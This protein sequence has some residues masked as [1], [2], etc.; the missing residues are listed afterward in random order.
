M[1]DQDD[2]ME[3][4]RKVLLIDDDQEFLTDLSFMLGG[5]YQVVT[6]TGGKEGIELLERDGADL[7]ILDLN[8]P[9]FYGEDDA[10]EGVAVLRTIRGKRGALRGARIPVVILS[11]AIT[12]EARRECEQLQADAFFAKPPGIQELRSRI[13]ELLGKQIEP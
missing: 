11:K 7:V 12:N 13:D 8:M 6:A 3:K 4:H 1:R 10:T 2:R 9:S 5:A